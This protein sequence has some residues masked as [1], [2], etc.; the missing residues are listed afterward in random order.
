MPNHSFKS[1]QKKKLEDMLSET[2]ITLYKSILKYNNYCEG[3]KDVP[4]VNSITELTI[5]KK[6]YLWL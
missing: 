4:A 2:D 6:I 3:Y 1:S 5:G